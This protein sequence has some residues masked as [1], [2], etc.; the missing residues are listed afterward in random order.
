MGRGAGHQRCWAAITAWVLTLGGGAALGQT[1]AEQQRYQQRMQQLFIRL[2]RNGDRRL[3]RQEVE[4]QPYLERH[5]ERLDQQ[6]RGFLVPADLAPGAHTRG[7]RSGRFFKRADRNGDGRI[8]RREAEAYSWLLRHFGRA[9]RNG[10]GSVDRQEL[11]GLAEQ[12]RR[13]LSAPAQP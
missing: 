12:R 7:E 4:G 1:P 2:D 13:S 6:Q 8:D 10:D 11:R 5:F 9:D 3:Q